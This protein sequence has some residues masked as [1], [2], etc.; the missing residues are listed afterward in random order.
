[1]SL[2]ARTQAFYRHA[3]EILTVSGVPF[4]VGGAYAMAHYTGIERH[5]KDLDVFTRREDTPRALD[6]LAAGGADTDLCFPHWLGKAREHDDYIDIIFSSGNGV[7]QV[8]DRWF[9]HAE[10][11]TVFGVPVRVVP[12]EE[13]IWSKG[14]IMERE[15]FDGSDLAH[16]FLARGHRLD[17]TRLGERFGDHWRVLLAH[18]VLF[19]F[20]YPDKRH[21]VPPEV[22][23]TLIRRLRED[24]SDGRTGLRMCGGT[25]LSRQQYLIDVERRG[26]RDARLVPFGSMSAEDIALWTKAIESDRDSDGHYSIK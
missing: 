23:D 19:G 25:L 3:L 13:M 26:Y 7:A 22:M 18:L 17:W 24:P 1:V 4:L 14:F 16:L 12:P 8:D 2:P 9:L 20:I 15:R 5:T 6:V 21:A 11:A 10:P